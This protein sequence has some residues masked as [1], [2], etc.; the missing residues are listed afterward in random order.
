VILRGEG[1]A[2]VRGGRLLFESLGLHLD[3]GDAIHVTGPN[4]SGKS[5]LIRLVAG[6]L[7][8]NAGRFERVRAALADEGLALDR[9]LSLGR[10]IAFW[11]GPHLA[12]AMVA[13]QLDELAHVPVRLLSAGQAKRA[14]LARVMASGAPLWLLDEPL[15]GLDRAGAKQLEAAISAHREG[16]GAVLAASHQPLFGDWHGLEL[17]Q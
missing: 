9:E 6:L 7:R 11:K 2:L 10:A 5:S 4:G 16:G 3:P 1:L 15:N 17:G 8:P 14:S 13:Y 12:R